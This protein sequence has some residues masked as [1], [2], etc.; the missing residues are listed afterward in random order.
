MAVWLMV[1]WYNFF[2]SLQSNPYHFWH[3]NVM[4]SVYDSMTINNWFWIGWLY[5]LTSSCAITLNHN[6]SSA[7]PF[8]HDYGG[9]VLILWHLPAS[10]LS[11]L[12]S[13]SH[14][15]HRRDN[16]YCWQ[17]LFT[18]P[19]PSNRFLFRASASVGVCLA[20]CCLAMGMACTT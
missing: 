20:T 5:L 8:F 12:M 15:L 16:L 18:M 3:Q 13:T 2:C 4:S 11:S 14:E 17:S 9:L 6:Q 1:W 7:E 19:L 10:E